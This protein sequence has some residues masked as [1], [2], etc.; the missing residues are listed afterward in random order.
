[1]NSATTST[2]SLRGI[3]PKTFLSY[4]FK[5]RGIADTLCHHLRGKGFH[6]RKEDET[7]LVGHRL[8][9]ELPRRIGD[10]ECFLPIIT[11]SSS[12]S[13]WVREEFRYA[14]EWSKKKRMIIAPV[15]LSRDGSLN[16]LSDFAYIDA[17]KDGLSPSVLEATEMVLLSAVRL[18][19]IE[20]DNPLRV[21]HA[22]A[23]RL[24]HSEDA[25]K[26]V[27]L[28]SSGYWLRVV[29]SLI[30][31]AAKIDP[32]QEAQAEQ[33]IQQELE[34]R[35]TI[36]WMFSVLDHVTN[37]MA[38]KVMERRAQGIVEDHHMAI[39]LQFFYRILFAKH[40]FDTLQKVLPGRIMTIGELAQ[41]DLARLKVIA[42]DGTS[43][44]QGFGFFM[45]QSKMNKAIG[46]ALDCVLANTDLRDYDTSRRPLAGLRLTLARHKRTSVRGAF[47]RFEIQVPRIVVPYLLGTQI[48]PHPNAKEWAWTLFA[49]PQIAIAAM[50][51]G[52][53]HQGQPDQ[54]VALAIKDGTGWDVNDYELIAP[55]D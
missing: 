34:S 47:A 48:L 14:E 22:D 15:V 31:W 13:Q 50:Q 39:V 35:R 11:E 25:G 42:H 32:S 24:F 10:A 38:E 33:F 19:K 1:M 46:W 2:T 18:L 37:S 52:G 8:A 41:K 26:R 6:V 7:T 5:D 27:I 12:N 53:A 17:T 3:G 30:A 29:D 20:D 43:D 21:Q 28:D 54:A 40:L 51:I 16:W 55:A 49:L 45:A 4:S 36:Q 23:E 9:A 44:M